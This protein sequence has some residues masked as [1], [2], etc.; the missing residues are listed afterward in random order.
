MNK[1]II[2]ARIKTD[3]DKIIEMYDYFG[4]DILDLAEEYNVLPA[5]MCNKLHTW[6]IKIR[7]GDYH[8]E[9]ELIKQK[10]KVSKELLDMR[11]YNTKVN[12]K[13]IKYINF[14][15]TTEDQRLVDNIINH[16]LK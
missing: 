3:K 10:T 2:G 15:N 1:N 9:R 4:A 6:G 7:S 5:T 14:I 12:N 13:K 16:P 8:R 11:A